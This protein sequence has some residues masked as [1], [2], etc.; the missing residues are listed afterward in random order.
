MTEY[1]FNKDEIKE[2]LSIDQVADLV[3]ELGGEPRLY[4]DQNL[5]VAKTICHCG[6]SHKLYYYDNTRLFRC[7]TGC[8]NDTF[9]IF[10]LVQKVKGAADAELPLPKA[11]SYVAQFYGISAKTNDFSETQEN[12]PDWNILKKYD[13]INSVDKIEKQNVEFK[14]YNEDILKHLPHPRIIHW[15][16]E[17]ISREVMESRGICFNPLSQGIVI[18]HYDELGQLI[19]IRERTIIAEEEKYGKYKP[20]I[21]NGKMY[22][23]PLGFALYN[24]NFSQENIHRFG[25]AIVF[26]G[27]R[28]S[29]PSLLFPVVAGGLK[30][31]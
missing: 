20:A 19:G 29:R 17:G 16:K 4:R 22:N 9:D 15:E 2:S 7:Y 23:H 26:E 27:K 12:L 11:V 18:P 3:A 25:R 30:Y 5:F 31:N 24:L 8:E 14:D 28:Q 21:I 13:K 1:Q 10:G 6:N